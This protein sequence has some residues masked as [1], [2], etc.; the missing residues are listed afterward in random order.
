MTSGAVVSLP[1]SEGG[2]ENV[3]AGVLSLCHGGAACPSFS[4]DCYLVF[5]KTCP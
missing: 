2:C 3:H 5:L 1:S 4:L